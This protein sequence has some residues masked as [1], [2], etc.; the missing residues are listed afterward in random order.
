M[1]GKKH[2]PLIPGFT[3]LEIIIVVVLLGITFAVTAPLMFAVVDG[4]RLAVDRNTMS[5]SANLAMDKMI[6]EMRQIKSKASV[7][8][9]S[10]STFRFI[11]IN[12]NDITFN[13]SSGHLMRTIGATSNQLA[14]NVSSLS[15]TYY[16]SAGAQIATPQVNPSDTD[17]KRVVI[18]LTFS[19]GGTQLAL[20]SGVSPRRLQ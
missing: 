13:L 19:L 14:D 4:W 18:D 6:R 8:T 2:F 16:N 3:L 5:E 17:I 11:D 20:K 1:S 10:G 12:D 15:F 9:A 7:I